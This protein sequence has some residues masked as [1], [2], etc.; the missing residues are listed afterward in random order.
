MRLYICLCD[1]SKKFNNEV[2]SFVD[3]LTGV[4]IFTLHNAV[5]LAK[6]GR[7]LE[8]FCVVLAWNRGYDTDL[9]TQLQLDH[10][11]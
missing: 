10:L 5:A 7:H 9:H 8:H 3:V 11:P 6:C 4:E 1:G 2:L